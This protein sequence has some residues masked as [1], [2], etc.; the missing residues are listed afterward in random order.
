VELQHFLHWMRELH[1]HHVRRVF[2]AL[3]TYGIVAAA[4]VE[5]TEPVVHALHLPEWTLTFVVIALGL[6][7]PVVAVIAWASSAPAPARAEAPAGPIS[8][9][10]PADRPAVTRRRITPRVAAALVGAG[11][12]VAAP[13]LTYYFVLRG[14]SGE[15]GG[16]AA[17]AASIAVLPFS[18]L[19]AAKDQGYFADGIAEEILNVLVHM[20]GLRVAGRTSSFSYKN[21][22][23][24]IPEIGRELNVSSV[25]EGSVRKEGNRVRVTAQLVDAARGDHIW[26]ESY[27]RE[28]TGIFA[29]QDEIA[30]AVAEALRVKILPG[31]G[32][33]ARQHATNPE[34]YSD[35]L[36]ARHY[37]DLATP[38][39]MSRSVEVLE[40]SLARDPQYAPAWAWL[41]VS[42]LNSSIYLAK[43]EDPP[44]KV[45]DA[46]RRAVAAADRAVAL[47][48]DLAECWSARA[49]MRTSIQWDW[50][51][52]RADFQRALAI[53]P[54][55]TNI[56]VR[57]SHLL[58]V[59]GKLSEAIATVR[60]VIEIDPLYP[61]GWDFLADYELGSGR[62]DLAR[63]A[64]SRALELA[65]DHVYSTMSLGQAHLLL[66]QPR[67][68]LAVFQ[69]NRS[70]V[71]RL[72]GTAIAQHDLGDKAAEEKAFEVLRARFSET[73]P[74]EIAVVYA[75]RGDR[76]A[77]IAWLDR[78]V[79]ERGGRGVSRL[80]IRRINRDPTL[81]KVRGDPRF[82]ALLRRMGLLP[83]G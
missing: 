2:R 5:V 14:R 7:F 29:V 17:T 74:Y 58:A 80:L 47:A 45:E 82:G 12:L 6:G 46:A 34:A 26:S 69:R 43:P 3:A 62:P 67:E 59:V 4:L 42:I 39:G 61:W 23:A 20:D 32:L 44:A 16:P 73:E 35:Y 79:A 66:G 75:W 30:H 28:L 15:R 77:A 68:A 72:A 76:D 83:A 21:K 9:L 24:T 8:A 64:A 57:Q 48:P 63:D 40:K 50:A 31:R 36:L 25:L 19:S 60:K 33:D 22:S 55:D 56:L 65:P 13:G 81:A 78:A 18:D 10:A 49:W 1:R 41:S 71:L 51:G 11:L 54:R 52:A 37:F 27:D 38:E 53:S 70:E